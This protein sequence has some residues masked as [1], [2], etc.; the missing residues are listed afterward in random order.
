VINTNVHFL[1]ILHAFRFEVI[2]IFEV[3]LE[4]LN[5]IK[6]IIQARYRLIQRYIQNEQLL[7]IL[8]KR[9]ID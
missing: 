5:K 1:I 3:Q 4:N 2:I 8:F 7:K 9:N 6:N